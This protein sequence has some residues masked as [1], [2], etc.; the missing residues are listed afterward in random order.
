MEAWAQVARTW[1]EARNRAA[2]AETVRQRFKYLP[3]RCPGI[4]ILERGGIQY[5][6]CGAACDTFNTV[7]GRPRWGAAVRAPGH[8]RGPAHS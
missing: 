2:M 7:C 1:S 6:D 4:R 3:S 8:A 5:V